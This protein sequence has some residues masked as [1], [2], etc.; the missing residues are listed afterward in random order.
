MLAIERIGSQTLTQACRSAQPAKEVGED[1][2]AVGSDIKEGQ[3]VLEKG[4]LLGPAEIGILATV[5]AS[6]L[7]VKLLSRH[8]G[9]FQYTYDS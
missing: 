6:S 4:T 3:L 7:E 8:F 5:G 2:R 1:V 9:Y